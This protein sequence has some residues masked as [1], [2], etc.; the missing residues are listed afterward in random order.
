MNSHDP[1]AVRHENIDESIL[2]PSE[3]AI[4]DTLSL[5]HYEQDRVRRGIPPLTKW[6]KD[7]LLSERI[8]HCVFSDRE[9]L[10]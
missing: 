4:F 5:H 6:Q 3:R 8:W 1:D 7:C 9:D 2:L 10:W